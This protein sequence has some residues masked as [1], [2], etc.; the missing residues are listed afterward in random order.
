MK[1]KTALYSCAADAYRNREAIIHSF[2]TLTQLSSIDGGTSAGGLSAPP[3][4]KDDRAMSAVLALMG[5]RQ[6]ARWTFDAPPPMPIQRRTVNRMQDIVI[7]RRERSSAVR[8]ALYGW[9]F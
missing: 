9:K 6:T 7:C 5:V 4:Q 8:R 2:E 3:G 1:G